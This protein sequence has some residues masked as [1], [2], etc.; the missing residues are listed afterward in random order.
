MCALGLRIQTSSVQPRVPSTRPVC[1]VGVSLNPCVPSMPSECWEFCARPR[2]DMGGQGVRG[3][4]AP[5][6]RAGLG[7]AQRPTTRL[8]L[9]RHTSI[10]LPP[11]VLRSKHCTD[12]TS[13][14]PYN[15]PP[16]GFYHTSITQKEIPFSKC[17]IRTEKHWDPKYPARGP[18][19]N[20]HIRNTP[21][22]PELPWAPSLLPCA[23]PNR[24][25]L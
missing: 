21:A 10:P 17:D 18:Q 15:R 5:C 2:W 23:L 25:R 3:A 20:A 16:R 1:P 8:T 9:A 19:M 6:C 11:A 14:Y 7:G 24:H 12:T 4:P 22:P 13:F